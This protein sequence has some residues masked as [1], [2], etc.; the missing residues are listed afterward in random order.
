MKLLIDCN[1]VFDI[2][3][4]G[5]F[6]SGGEHDDAVEHHL[7]SC[8]D[9]RQ[10][11]EALRPA[12][13]LFHECLSDQEAEALPEYHGQAT[14]LSRS[15]EDSLYR[16]LPRHVDDVRMEAL[17]GETRLAAHAREARQDARVGRGALLLQ[18]LIG[19]ALTAAIVLTVI[20]LGMSV[21]NMERGHGLRRPSELASNIQL[22]P[23]ST[24]TEAAQRL[25]SWQL[26]S[27]CLLEGLRERVASGKLAERSTLPEQLAFAWEEHAIDCCKR[28]HYA[29]E[30]LLDAA[31]QNTRMVALVQNSCIVCHADGVG[32]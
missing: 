20:S 6:P 30:S 25:L 22:A 8:H 7:R 28:C 1:E 21:R 32:A 18:G 3:T 12:V 27:D 14:P 26:P 23:V 10:L 24:S 31:R 19:M 15:L 9:C 13:E 5:P 17:E 16:S 2:L 29:R 11:A 4:R